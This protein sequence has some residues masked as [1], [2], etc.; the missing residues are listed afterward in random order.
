VQEQVAATLLDPRNMPDLNCI[1]PAQHDQAWAL[2]RAMV[3]AVIDEVKNSDAS[4]D[5]N[6]SIE[7]VTDFLVTAS[8]A[9]AVNSL[10]LSSAKVAD[11]E[12]KIRLAP[13]PFP[14]TRILSTSG[15][16]VLCIFPLG[17]VSWRGV[18]LLF[19]QLQ[20]VPSASFPRRVT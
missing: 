12:I 1:L 14:R 19:L 10:D 15:V 18:Y 2:L 4:T 11:R 16:A 5:V 3:I 20:Q 6:D 13:S 7:D 9:A 8:A 17:W